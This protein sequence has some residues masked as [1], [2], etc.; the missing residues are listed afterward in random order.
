MRVFYVTCATSWRNPG[1]KAKGW[2]DGAHVAGFYDAW[3]EGVANTIV[4]FART[5][6]AISPD[7]LAAESVETLSGVCVCGRI[8]I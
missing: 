8:L 1:D 4:H 3:H 7:R 2:P 5:L 6:K